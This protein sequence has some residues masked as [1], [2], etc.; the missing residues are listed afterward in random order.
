[1]RNDYSNIKTMSHERQ[2]YD[3]MEK[4]LDLSKSDVIKA[5]R[6]HLGFVDYQKGILLK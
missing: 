1:M 6:N 5:G 3:D 4:S 2:H